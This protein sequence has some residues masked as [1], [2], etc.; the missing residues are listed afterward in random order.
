MHRKK[1]AVLASG[2]GTNLQAI[3]DAVVDGYIDADPCLVLTDR[4]EVRALDRATIAKIPTAILPFSDFRNR[5]EF[6]D[7]V[8]Q[9]VREHDADFIALAG[10]MRILSPSAPAAFPNA[11]INTHPALLPAFPGAHAVEQA[12]DH[13]AKVTGCTVHFVDEGTDTGPIISQEAVPILPGDDVNSLHERIKTVEHR[14]F[15]AALAAFAA[16]RIVV[17]GRKVLLTDS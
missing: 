10:F 2:S 14:L 3:I 15:P 4:P 16:E 1:F 5:P 12:L 13:A 6:T 7:A 8:I 9:L 17:D 11:I